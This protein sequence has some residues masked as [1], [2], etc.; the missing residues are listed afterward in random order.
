MHHIDGYDE[1]KP[2]NSNANKM[3]TLCRDCHSKV[4]AGVTIPEEILESIG[5]FD[6]CNE[7]CNADV[8]DVKRIGNVEKEIEKEKDIETEIDCAPKKA[9]KEQF[10]TGFS[11]YLSTK[12]V[13]DVFREH[14]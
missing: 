9:V 12:E 4:H 3:L 7:S 13:D 6:E 10:S 5:Y 14:L 2:Q 11:T 1:S 8:T